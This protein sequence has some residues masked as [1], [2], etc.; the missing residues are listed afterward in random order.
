MISM[1]RL[2]PVFQRPVTITG[3]ILSV[4]VLA[5]L[6]I[7]GAAG[8]SATASAVDMTEAGAF[9]DWR[10]YTS[11]EGGK[12]VCFMH[13][14]PTSSR[15][16]EGR[17]RGAVS[18]QISHRPEDARYDEIVINIGYPFADGKQAQVK[19][20]AKR[21]SMFTQ[22]EHAWNYGSQADRDMVKA[23]KAGSTMIVEGESSRGT[24]TTDEFS[25][26][27]STAAYEKLEA[28]CPRK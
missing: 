7:A 15:G 1:R 6:A 5:M 20:G 4:P 10:V 3:R 21:F 24:T 8:F 17:Q 22:E 18:V 26:S 2:S 12:K 28:E 27:G 9:N 19:I 23:I 16:A 25:L 13:S 11:T 14:E